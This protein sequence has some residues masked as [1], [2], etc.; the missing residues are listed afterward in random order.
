MF[1]WLFK[2][3]QKTRTVEE[4]GVKTTFD[5]YDSNQEL[6]SGLKRFFIIIHK[7]LPKEII[8]SHISYFFYDL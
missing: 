5:V 1:S 8:I 4:N 7:N 6:V 2:K 3:K